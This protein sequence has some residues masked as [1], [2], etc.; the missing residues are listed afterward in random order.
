MYWLFLTEY[1]FYYLK[2]K[3]KTRGK[4]KMII[5]WNVTQFC[6]QDRYHVVEEPTES[7]FLYSTLWCWQQFHSKQWYLST[8]FTLN[9]EAALDSDMFVST[10]TTTRHIITEDHTSNVTVP[11]LTLILIMK[12]N[13]MHC[14]SNLFDKVLYVFRIGP[15]S[16]IRSISTLYTRNWY[17]SCWFCWRLLADANRTSTYCVYTM[18]R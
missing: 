7:I 5:F 3:N 12:A 10:Y 2:K 15:L 16:I 14:V 6:V 4:V 18:L 8:V 9:I 13:E 11:Y 17:L 1:Q